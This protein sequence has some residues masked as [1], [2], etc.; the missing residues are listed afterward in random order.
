MAI[1]SETK[2][3]IKVI[4][5]KMNLH[6]AADSDDAKI[7]KS[8]SLE[9]PAIMKIIESLNEEELNNLCDEYEGFYHLM[10]LLEDLAKG[11]ADGTITN[12]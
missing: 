5:S 7:L 2:N 3:F 10:T 12:D 11:F 9:I 4:N 8:M 6:F 1:S